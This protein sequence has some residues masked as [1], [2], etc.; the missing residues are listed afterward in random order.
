MAVEAM[1][2][3]LHLPDL[4]RPLAVEAVE[5]VVS[6]VR[7]VHPEAR[8]V[9]TARLTPQRPTRELPGK[10]TLEEQRPSLIPA[11]VEVAVELL[12]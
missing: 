7:P 11:V 2:G 8:A 9:E 3:L 5:M 1:V 4:Q 6:P 10:V 12:P